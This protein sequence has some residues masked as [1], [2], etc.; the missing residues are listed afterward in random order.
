M[1]A[2]KTFVVVAMT[3]MIGVLGASSATASDHDYRY[4][5]GFVLPCSLDG[6]NPALHPEIF[7]NAAAARSY[8]FVRST[9][10]R[11]HVMPNCHR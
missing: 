7:G 8:G 4:P 5:R 3:G 11:W 6:V 9:D 10:G 1:R 2:N